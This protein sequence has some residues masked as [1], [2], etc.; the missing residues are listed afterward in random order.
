[1]AQKDPAHIATTKTCKTW[2]RDFWNR[3]TALLKAR[4]HRNH[5]P[6]ACII[7]TFVDKHGVV[8]TVR[9]KLG[10]ENNTQQKL[11]WPL[12]KTVLLAEDEFPTKCKV[13]NQNEALILIGARWNEY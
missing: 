5:W 13:L 6:V 7:E 1:M 9:L 10:S 4:T 11:V 2:R 12:A 8:R 3:D